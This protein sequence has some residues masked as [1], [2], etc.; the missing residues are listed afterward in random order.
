ML[1]LISLYLPRACTGFSD[2]KE[3]CSED[4]D[5]ENKDPKKVRKQKPCNNSVVCWPIKLKL[6]RDII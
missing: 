4:E 2:L 3:G 5:S 6:G 1:Q